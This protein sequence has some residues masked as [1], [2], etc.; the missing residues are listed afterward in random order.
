MTTETKIRKQILRRIER[1]PDEHL[2]E[3]DD[4]LKKLENRSTKRDKILAYAGAWNDIDESVFR[5]FTEELL[6]RRT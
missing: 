2:A 3:I 4:Y 5:E 1:I 6:T